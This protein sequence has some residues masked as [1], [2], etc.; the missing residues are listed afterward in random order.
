METGDYNKCLGSCAP[1]NPTKAAH[2]AVVEDVKLL[3][4]GQCALADA[5][6]TV[7]WKRANALLKQPLLP[8]SNT[9]QLKLAGRTACSVHLYCDSE[10]CALQLRQLRV[11]RSV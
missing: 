5:L 10:H 7:L 8:L 4:A 11:Q 6:N 2:F 3:F 1:R 9:Y